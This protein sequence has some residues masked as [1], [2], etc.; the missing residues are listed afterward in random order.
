MILEDFSTDFN[1]DLKACNR[2]PEAEES[3]DDHQGPD[4]TVRVYYDS[5]DLSHG[6][7]LR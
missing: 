2:W 3:T 5:N 7:I 1:S 6:S 4:L